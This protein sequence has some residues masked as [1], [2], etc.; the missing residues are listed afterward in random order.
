M[1]RKAVRPAGFTLLEIML[2]LALMVIVAG[3]SMAALQGPL[4]N[5][6]LRKSGDIIRTEFS[7]ARVAAMRTGRVQI[8]RYETGGRMFSV[9]PWVQAEDYLELGGEALPQNASAGGLNAAPLSMQQTAVA[10]TNEL[11]D[12]VSFAG[13]GTVQDV[14]AMLDEQELLGGGGLGQTG[15]LLSG[16]GMWSSPI[17]FYPDGTSSTA[18]VLLVNQRGYYVEVKLRGLTG[19]ARASDLLSANEFVQ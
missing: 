5:Q 13:G 3:L 1:R 12:K 6:R 14:R 9:Q 7:R 11:P 19:L 16:S 17:L 10:R 8:F 2:V 4:D 18:Q 15:S